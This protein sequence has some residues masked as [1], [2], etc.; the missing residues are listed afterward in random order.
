MTPQVLQ[1]VK[2]S[3]LGLVLAT[4]TLWGITRERVT[5]IEGD[6]HTTHRA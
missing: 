5:L 2:D 4:R 3:Y 1:L 6:H